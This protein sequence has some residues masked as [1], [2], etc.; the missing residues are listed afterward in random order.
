MTAPEEYVDPSERGL[1]RTTTRLDRVSRSDGQVLACDQASNSQGFQP[2]MATSTEF[3]ISGFL[4]LVLYGSAT[5]LRII[6]ISKPDSTELMFLNRRGAGATWRGSHSSLQV[7]FVA[8]SH[9]TG[10]RAAS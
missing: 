5:R 7:Q 3:V 8:L 1:M 2:L 10:C 4:L 9:Q 6:E